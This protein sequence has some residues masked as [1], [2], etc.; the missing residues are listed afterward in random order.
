MSSDD[1]EYDPVD[2]IFASDPEGTTRA[3]IHEAA[4]VAAAEIVKHKSDHR[5][6]EYQRVLQGQTETAALSAFE[7][8][9]KAHG[10]D[11]NRVKPYVE[12]RLT[13]SPHLVPPDAM[14][15]PSRLTS[16]L[17]DVYQLARQEA[18]EAEAANH[19]QAVKAAKAGPFYVGSLPG[20]SDE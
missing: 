20:A 15:S 19:W 17:E 3:V 1:Y 16:A 5:E 13:E 2:E 6:M 11:W 10:S 4:A 7:S 9:E 14:T 12:K 18:N 8:L